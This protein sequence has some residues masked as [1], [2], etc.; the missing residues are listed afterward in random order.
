MKLL[1]L[2]LPILT[3]LIMYNLMRSRKVT[4]VEAK[5]LFVSKWWTR[6]LTTGNC[7]YNNQIEEEE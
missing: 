2:V 1:A 7:Y 5:M 3:F 6:S 4:C